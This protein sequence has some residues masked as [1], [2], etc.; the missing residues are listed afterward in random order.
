MIIPDVNILIH[1][2]DRDS[3]R[4]EVARSWWERTLNGERTVGVP[5][6]VILGFVRIMTSRSI[7]QRPRTVSET[8]ASVRSWFR[9]PRVR[10]VDSGHGHAD[11][12]FGCWKNLAQPAT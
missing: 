9:S 10:V 6:G 12:L 8:V 1:A 5:W 11:L 2:Y 4:H 7:L 3:P